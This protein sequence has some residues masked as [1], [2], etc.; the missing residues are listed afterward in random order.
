[1]KW[2]GYRSTTPV[3]DTPGALETAQ[4]VTRYVTGQLGRRKG[5]ARS[6]IGKLTG[7]VKA[8]S[9]FAVSPG[10]PRVVTSVG[11]TIDG[12][13]GINAQW[14][15]AV[16]TPVSGVSNPAT[17]SSFAIIIDRDDSQWATSVLIFARSGGNFPTDTEPGTFVGELTFNPWATQVSTNW[18][19]PSSTTWRFRAYPVRDRVQGAGANL[20]PVSHAVPA[21]TITQHYLYDMVG[22]IKVGDVT[23]DTPAAYTTGNGTDTATFNIYDALQA[24]AITLPY[25]Y[26]IST[27]GGGPG[28]FLPHALFSDCITVLPTSI[29]TGG[30]DLVNNNWVPG[31]VAHVNIAADGDVDTDYVVTIDQP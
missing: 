15:D 28:G 22:A 6:S 4:N 13:E 24:G 1:M 2:L 11:S 23:L 26:T 8:I 18:T 3:D 12:V 7:A 16:L 29:M 25:S 19:A 17:G 31:Q 14:G 30:R 21:A 20:L 9:D 27:S 5:M 10:L